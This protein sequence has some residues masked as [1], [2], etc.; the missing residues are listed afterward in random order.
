MSS[1]KPKILYIVTQA[2]WGGAQRYILE[3]ATAF[4]E[5]FD[6]TIATGRRGQSEFRILNLEFRIKEFKNLVR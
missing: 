4:R 3:L 2:Q 1:H 5:E 6:V